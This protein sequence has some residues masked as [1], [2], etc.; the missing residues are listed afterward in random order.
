MFRTNNNSN[1]NFCTIS[2]VLQHR[3][4]YTGQFLDLYWAIP[5]YVT[6]FW[7]N[8]PY[9]DYCHFNL[10][11]KIYTQLTYHGFSNY[12][13]TKKYY[14]LSSS[15]RWSDAHASLHL[16][17]RS[18][19]FGPLVPPLIACNGEMFTW[20]QCY[21]SN[22]SGLTS[23]SVLQLACSH[24]QTA[25][26]MA[27]DARILSQEDSRIAVNRQQTVQHTLTIGGRIRKSRDCKR[28]HSIHNRC[29]IKYIL[30]WKNVLQVLRIE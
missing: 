27:I 18:V 19:S 28:L 29:P 30:S 12:D 14:P 5:Y 23:T 24:N 16:S 3:V 25:V 17:R 2:Q 15:W 13:S 11:A 4:T 6:R 8:R 20:R 7:E 26:Q 22:G 10:W 21:Y 9:G 1:V